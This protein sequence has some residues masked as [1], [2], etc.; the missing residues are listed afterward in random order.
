[1]AGRTSWGGVCYRFP[2]QEEEMNKAFKQ[3]MDASKLQDLI[4]IGNFLSG[5]LLGGK[6][7][8][9]QAVQKIPGVCGG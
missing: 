9:E 1:M 5:Q 2:N 4:L 3:L 6:Y 8:S 7:S